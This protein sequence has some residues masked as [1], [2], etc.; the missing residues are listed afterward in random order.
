MYTLQVGSSHLCRLGRDIYLIHVMSRN[1]EDEKEQLLVIML[2]SRPEKFVIVLKALVGSYRMS[3]V[4]QQKSIFDSLVS[5]GFCS[6]LLLDCKSY[7]S[8]P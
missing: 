2:H 5:E 7:F 6:F 8:Y 3:P 4:T 1:S